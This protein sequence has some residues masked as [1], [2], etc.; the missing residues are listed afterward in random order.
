MAQ[1]RLGA[2]AYG[3]AGIRLAK[4]ERAGERHTFHDLTVRLRLEGD[5]A[6]A[7]VDGDNSTSLPTDTMR[8]TAYALAADLPLTETERYLE[9]L[10][11]RLLAA[12]PAATAAHAEAVV[13]RWERLAASGDAAGHPHAFRRASADGTASV[14]CR[15]DGPVR[16][17]SGLT[18]LTLAKTTGSGFAG[19]R[20]DEFTVLAETDDRVLAT[21]VEAEWT[22]LRPPESYAA[23]RPAVQAAVE[24]V[25]ATRY[26]P[27]VQ[28]TLYAAGEAALAAVPEIASIG[29]RLPNRHHVPVDLTPFGRPNRNEVFA[30]PDRPYGLIEGTVVRE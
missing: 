27:S 8:T 18:G 13:H 6:A 25:F 20:T 16:V 5:F 26:S 1:T 19:F 10:G 11:G 7:Y 30:V 14:T 3:K 23:A 28:H 29:F 24:E 9:A 2:H 15:R 17:R 4:V 21:E 22:W 12:A